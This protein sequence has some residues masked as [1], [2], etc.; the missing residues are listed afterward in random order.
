MRVET[1]VTI[2]M[3]SD[4]EKET[5]ADLL[6]TSEEGLFQSM[7]GISRKLRDEEED[8][9][10]ESFRLVYQRGGFTTEELNLILF[11]GVQKVAMIPPASVEQKEEGNE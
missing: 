7:R 4:A 11:F 1:I 6:G 2:P 8:D 9:L 10:I 5:L 3:I